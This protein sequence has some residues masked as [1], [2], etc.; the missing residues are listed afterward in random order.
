[1]KTHLLFAFALSIT[2]TLLS[3]CGKGIS[4]KDGLIDWDRVR[5]TLVITLPDNS[6][7]AVDNALYYSDLPDSQDCSSVLA[8]FTNKER[9]IF[10]DLSLLFEKGKTEVGKEMDFR[11]VS[12]SFSTSS[13]SNDYTQ[14]YTGHIYLDGIGDSG[15]LLRMQDVTFTI[16]RALPPSRGA[17]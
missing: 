10:L 3:S 9:G 5:S 12:F 11:R 15:I 7:V 4:S 14:T 6:Q 16:A 17:E 1:M 2:L 8:F 13:N